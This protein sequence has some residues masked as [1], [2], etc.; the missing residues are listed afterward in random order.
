MAIALLAGC[1][2]DDD[3]GDDA[4]PTTEADDATTTEPDD[5]STTGSG[6]GTE[7]AGDGAVTI[8]GFAFDPEDVT[9]AAGTTVTWTNEDSATHTATGDED[10]FDTE[11]I[12][13]GES[14]EFTFEEPGTFA[15]HCDIHPNMTASVVVE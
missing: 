5:P 9:V 15:Y 10:E 11:S 4:A 1:G 8:Q 2:G 7:P 6:G 14:G 3:G 13:N 12:G